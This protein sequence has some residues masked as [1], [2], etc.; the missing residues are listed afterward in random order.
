MEF[1]RKGDWKRDSHSDRNPVWLVLAFGMRNCLD[2]QRDF[3]LLVL[4]PAPFSWPNPILICCVWCWDDQGQGIGIML[5]RCLIAKDISLYTNVRWKI[6]CQYL[7]SLRSLGFLPYS[8]LRF[9]SHDEKR[10]TED[11]KKLKLRMSTLKNPH[12]S[13]V[14]F[15]KGVQ[16]WVRLFVLEG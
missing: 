4:T 10:K 6:P 11:L 7:Y 12:H 13:N 15:P 2:T 16:R 5:W 8:S 1:K 3:H 9:I 14:M